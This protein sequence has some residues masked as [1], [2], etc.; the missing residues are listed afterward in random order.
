MDG[1]PEWLIP[2]RII[3]REIVQAG[4]GCGKSA[5]DRLPRRLVQYRGY[6]REPE[7]PS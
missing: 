2:Q 4:G 3:A 7:T 6:V 5:G 1:E